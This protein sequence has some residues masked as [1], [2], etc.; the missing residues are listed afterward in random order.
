MDSITIDL[1]G[2]SCALTREP[3]AELRDL[4]AGDAGRASSRRDLSLILE[5][6]LCD[7]RAV[8]LRRGEARALASLLA[9]HPVAPEFE[10]LLI[11]LAA[12]LQ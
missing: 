10:P 1:N 3:L 6:A 7:R 12:G 4:A 8:V 2:R 11:A 5:Q 9:S